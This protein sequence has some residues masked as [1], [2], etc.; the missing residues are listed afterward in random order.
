MARTITIEAIRAFEN[1]RNYCKS[2][3][4]V[5]N[6]ALYLWGN[7]IAYKENNKLFISLCGYNTV[8]T[9][10]RLNGLTGV[11]VQSRNFTPYINDVE[12]SSYGTYQINGNEVI[13]VN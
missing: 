3:T 13:R 5:K 11:R 2:N 6:D 1:G 4:M 8:T 10:E 9:R 7:K 12:V